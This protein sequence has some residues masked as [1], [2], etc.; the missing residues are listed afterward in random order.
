MSS[1]TVT[2][3]FLY[4]LKEIFLIDLAKF[5]NELQSSS[6][7]FAYGFKLALK[8]ISLLK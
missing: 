3:L 2:P 7:G 8:S 1:E 6:F 4:A 5:D